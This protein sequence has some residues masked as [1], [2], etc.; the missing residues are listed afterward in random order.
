MKNQW[1]LCA[2]LCWCNHICADALD[3]THFN[4]DCDFPII[5]STLY[6]TSGFTNREISPGNSDVDEYTSM[7]DLVIQ[8]TVPKLNSRSCTLKIKSDWSIVVKPALENVV[9]VSSNNGWE[10]CMIQGPLGD[11]PLY[12][13][14]KLPGI[15]GKCDQVFNPP[16]PASS[17]CKEK[18]L[19]CCYSPNWWQYQ[20][21]RYYPPTVKCIDGKFSGNEHDASTLLDIDRG[22]MRFKGKPFFPVVRLEEYTGDF[23]NH[24]FPNFCLNNSYQGE[25]RTVY[26]IVNINPIHGVTTDERIWVD[27]DDVVN[28][29]EPARLSLCEP[30][31]KDTSS[32]G[33]ARGG[34]Y[35]FTSGW[36]VGGKLG[37]TIPMKVFTLAVEGNGGYSKSTTTSQTVALS[38]SPKCGYHAAITGDALIHHS[39][40]QYTITYP[41]DGYDG[42]D[43]CRMIVIDFV[44]QDFARSKNFNGYKNSG[45]IDVKPCGYP[46]LDGSF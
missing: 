6:D 20:M 18:D 31:C 38:T 44:A 15:P 9:K 13:E 16:G 12:T 32:N 27:V 5:A 14:Q 7:G 23:V 10:S 1:T 17:T 35:S 4:N 11:L 25:L 39:M 29:S 28:A 42:F 21:G 45:G 8:I 41:D 36:N 37:A 33:A 19:C 24:Y 34:T 26:D 2:L 46:L 3:H 22:V 30:D 43:G 40:A